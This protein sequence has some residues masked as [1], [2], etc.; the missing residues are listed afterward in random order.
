MLGILGG[1]D[2]GKGG[3]AGGEGARE[4]LLELSMNGVNLTAS[5]D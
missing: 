5:L 2:R 3:K 1:R 4:S